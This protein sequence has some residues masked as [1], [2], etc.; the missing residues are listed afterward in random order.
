[1]KKPVEVLVVDDDTDIADSLALVIE[2]RGHKVTVAYTGEEAM[3]LVKKQHFDVAF[4]DIMMPGKT[5]VESLYEVKR[6]QPGLTVYMMTGF[7]VEDLV[8]QALSGGAL[9]VLR[10]PILAEQVLTL[11][12]GSKRG[13]LLIGDEDNDIVR[14][15]GPALTEAGWPTITARNGTEAHT[16]ICNT[17]IKAMILDASDATLSSVEV[18]SEV[19]RMGRNV[20]TVIVAGDHE[21]AI[22]GRRG[23]VAHLR[24]PVD[25]IDV[26][27]LVEHA[28]PALRVAK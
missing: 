28:K 10:K 21:P 19:M 27:T 9:G 18:C 20:P 13:P 2:A 1:M 11:L 7:S 26:L 8:E 12:A 6:L 14:A 3:K 22:A 24:K 25:P 15:I 4:L 17:E 23:S 16:R 5:G